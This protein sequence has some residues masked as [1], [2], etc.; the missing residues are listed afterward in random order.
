MF[1]CYFVDHFNIHCNNTMIDSTSS[2]PLDVRLYSTLG[3]IS[4]YECLSNIPFFSSSFSR[5][6]NVLLL[7]P[8]RA[9]LNCLCLTG[10]VVQHK[11]IKISNV[12]LLV[13]ISLS[14][15]VSIIKEETSYLS[16]PHFSLENYN[17]FFLKKNIK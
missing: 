17:C 11:G 5:V 13:K 8:F 15:E 4:L 12:P 2:C 16:K 10:F 7:N 1:F 9:S 14:F 3:G 6:A